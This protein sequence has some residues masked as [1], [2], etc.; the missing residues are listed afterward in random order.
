MINQGFSSSLKHFQ[1]DE[2]IFAEG[3]PGE[4]AY[5]IESGRVEV[6]V[7]VNGHP[8][9]LGILTRGDVLG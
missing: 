6:A 2:M 4:W 3:D 8:Y 5:I 7:S 9:P 1:R